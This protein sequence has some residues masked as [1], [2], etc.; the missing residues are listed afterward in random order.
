MQLVPLTEQHLDWLTG[1]AGETE[2]ARFTRFPVPVPA[3]WAR[4]WYEKYRAGRVDGTREAFVAVDSEGRYLG[5]AL[6]PEIEPEGHE[7]EL[8]YLVDP[9]ARGRGVATELLRLLTDW[10]FSHQHAERI[11]LMIDAQNLGSQKAAARNG[12]HLE[13]TLRSAYFKNGQRTDVQIWSKLPT[14]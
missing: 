1:L 11:Q 3:G 9:A 12:Y 5:L 10:A 6:A 13:G 4:S 2:V 7:L 14:D 8:G